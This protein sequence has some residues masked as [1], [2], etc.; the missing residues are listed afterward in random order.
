MSRP[1]FVFTFARKAVRTLE[2]HLEGWGAK[3][4]SG[5]EP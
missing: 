5:G 4:R 1:F 3:E 2:S